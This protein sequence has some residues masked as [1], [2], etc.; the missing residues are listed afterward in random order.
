MLEIG[1]AEVAQFVADDLMD[2]ALLAQCLRA[3]AS[4]MSGIGTDLEQNLPTRLGA[5]RRMRDR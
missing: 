5:F 3:S 4:D 2:R 1:E